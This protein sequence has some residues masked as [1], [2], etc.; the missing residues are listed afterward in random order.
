L[1]YG[2]TQ[3]GGVPQFGQPWG[4]VFQITTNGVHT[5]LAAFSVVTGGQLGFG[6]SE[7]A[8]GLLYGYAFGANQ[9]NSRI[10][11]LVAAPTPIIKS[12]WRS[13][14]VFGNQHVNVSWDAL[15]TQ[16]YRIEYKTS[17]SQPDWT[18][19]PG[20]AYTDND[21]EIVFE[22]V[23]D[24]DNPRFYRLVLLLP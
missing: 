17:L 18:V 19:I 12:I 5:V 24:P 22:D 21:Q 6:L 23:F 16:A 11:R 13:E 2:V 20:A 14:D 3:F 8:D 10:F 4:T 7:G 9:S 15:A 1:L